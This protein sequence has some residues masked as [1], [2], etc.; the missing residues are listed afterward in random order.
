MKKFLLV[1]IA[2]QLIKGAKTFAGAEV[3]GQ[4][5]IQGE[6]SVEFALVPY[7]GGFIKASEGDWLVTY[8]DGVKELFNDETFQ[9]TFSAA[10]ETEEVENTPPEV[11]VLTTF[12]HEVTQ[13][14]IDN[15]PQF[16]ID[17]IKVGDIIQVPKDKSEGPE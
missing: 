10:P 1:V 17:G 8:D 13:E 14:D 2:E 7:Q 5:V 4:S 9:S 15:N 3:K 12:D 6:D 11:L 16:V